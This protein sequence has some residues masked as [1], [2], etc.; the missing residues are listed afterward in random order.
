M[1]IEDGRVVARGPQR[2]AP[3][4]VDA[5]DLAGSW[6]L[7]A[8]NDAHCHILPTGLDLRKLHLGTLSTHE[9]VLEAVRDRLPSVE[10]GDWLQAVHYDQTRFP[11]LGHLHRDQLDAV[12]SSIPILL[13]H[14]NGH[15][16]VANSA[17]LA[18]AGVDETTADPSGGTYERDAQGRLTGVLLERAHEHVSHAK[19]MP[20]LEEMT[21][22]ILDAARSMRG[23]GITCAA[24]MMTGQWDLERELQ[25]FRLAS[26]RGCQVRLRLYAQWSAVFGPRA[27]A[28][29]RLREHIQAMD[30]ERCKVAGVK[31]FADGAI[32][33]ATAGIYGRFLTSK[34]GGDTDGQMIYRPDRLR[35]MVRHAHD[36]GYSVSVHS[37]G[38]RSTDLVMDAFEAVD[39]PTRHRL[40]HAMLLS[41]DQIDRL[42]R[43]GCHVAMQPEFLHEL[44]HA[45][46]RQ[47]GPERASTLKRARS[48]LDAGIRLSFNSDRP[49]VAGDPWT[50]IRTAVHRPAGFDPSEN[51]SAVEALNAYTAG[52]ADACDEG[53]DLGQLEPGQW[54][55][56]QVLGSDPR[57]LR[58][59]GDGPSPRRARCELGRGGP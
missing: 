37:I 44:G 22:A 49:I 15:A 53:E 41:D 39:D 38:D 7:P 32:G 40:E 59:V 6:I 45:Y 2:P 4:G 52:G 14:S 25:A 42:A 8:F 46:K 26:E 1:L 9:E 36:A 16:S 57:D 58:A 55:D 21:E 28:P 24:D 50:G 17:A 29:E 48:A 5:E 19:P 12:S 11:D 27:M 3:E 30:P 43:L 51:L 10:P 23:L 18:K 33:S 34:G 35:S 20:S 54:A 13:R 47:L 56:F 31:I